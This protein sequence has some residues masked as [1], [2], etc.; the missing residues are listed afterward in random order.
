MAET[1]AA[2]AAIRAVRAG[3]REAFGHLL[4]LYQRRLFG[5]TLMITR[6]PEGAEEVTQDAF[7]R[8]YSRLD[9][10]DEQRPFYPWLATIGARLAYNWLRRRGRVRATEGAS[11]DGQHQPVAATDPLDK[12]LT[13]ERGR[14]LWGAVAKL[15]SGERTAVATWRVAMNQLEIDLQDLPEPSPPD[16]LSLDVMARIARIDEDRRRAA[17]DQPTQPAAADARRD[18]WAWGAIVLGVAL[19]LGAPAYQLLV[20]EAALDLTSP[21]IGGGF[22]G[23]VEMIPASPATAVLAVGL[24]LYLT[25]LFA[26]RSENPA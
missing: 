7:V 2:R 4:E 20:G 23:V 17:A 22:H 6:D 9:H 10:Y 14:R 21:R 11:I 5:L 3:D 18:L 24:L 12:L 19:G 26:P 15:S 25:G 8:A 13:D 16:R 1:D